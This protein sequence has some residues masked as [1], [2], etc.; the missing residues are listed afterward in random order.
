MLRE[1]GVDTPLT[2]KSN[3]YENGLKERRTMKVEVEDGDGIGAEY[4]DEPIDE[5]AGEVNV[6][7]IPRNAIV[8]WVTVSPMH[9]DLDNDSNSRLG[10]LQSRV[11]WDKQY[12]IQFNPDYKA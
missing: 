6:S 1:D 12:T 7:Y 9:M 5:T 11:S 3:M 2:V 10:T 4:V 8:G